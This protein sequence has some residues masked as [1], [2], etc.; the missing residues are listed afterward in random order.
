MLEA[1]LESIPCAS[2]ARLVESQ[3]TSTGTASEMTLQALD[4]AFYLTMSGKAPL[5]A[6][7][8]CRRKAMRTWREA[9]VTL[10]WLPFSDIV[11]P[12]DFSSK[13]K[14]LKSEMSVDV[15]DFVK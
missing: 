13:G 15:F 7:L 6:D 3:A 4:P 8:R 5:R 2:R 12:L 9:S 10:I 14:G 1:Y 11:A